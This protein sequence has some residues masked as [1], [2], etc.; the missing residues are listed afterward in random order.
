[1][2][3]NSTNLINLCIKNNISLS[4][5][6]SCTGGNIC[7][8][9]VRIPNASSVFKYGIIAYSNEIKIKCLKVPRQ[10]IEKYGA[11][12]Q[13]TAASMAL[14]VNKILKKIDFS[15]AVTGIAGPGK[16]LTQKKVG[17]VYHSFYCK[18]LKDLQVIEKNYSGDRITIINKASFFS[19]QKS[20]EIIK[21]FV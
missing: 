20:F 2:K 16:D 4:I 17:L 11:V 15:F 19:I 7:S 1:M 3:I 8:A 5:A 9:L 18:R 12:S 14:G 6:E 13:Q 21:S 10:D